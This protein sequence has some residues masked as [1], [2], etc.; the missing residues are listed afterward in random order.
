MSADG[1]A[2]VVLDKSV[3]ELLW[4]VDQARHRSLTEEE[5]GTV[6]A[7]IHMAALLQEALRSKDVTLGKIRNIAFGGDTESTRNVLRK[8]AMKDDKGE[9][10]GAAPAADIPIFR[11]RNRRRTRR[12]RSRVT[13]ASAL[14]IIRARNRPGLSI[15]FCRPV[16]TP[17]AWLR[18]QGLSD[19]GRRTRSPVRDG[20]GAGTCVEA[21]AAALQPVQHGIHRA[22]A[23]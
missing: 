14:T 1:T 7:L 13:A 21:R 12:R 3:A 6:S 4:I 15:R 17:G 23:G 8:K 2:P 10:N 11:A 16:M 19:P 18:R 9:E 20:A 22:D 5:C